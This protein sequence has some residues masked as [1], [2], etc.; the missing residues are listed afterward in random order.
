MEN[1]TV[2]LTEDGF[3][4][5]GMFEVVSVNCKYFGFKANFMRVGQL[6]ES[7]C[8]RRRRVLT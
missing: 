1:R 4:C 7:N 2:I 3:M 5:S 8:L 6:S